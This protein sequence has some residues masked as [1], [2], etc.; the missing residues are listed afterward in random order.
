MHKQWWHYALSLV[1][2]FRIFLFEKLTAVVFVAWALMTLFAVSVASW[3]GV[4]ATL[5]V[6]VA[7]LLSYRPLQGFMLARKHLLI[8]RGDRVEYAPPGEGIEALGFEQATIL[9]PITPENVVRT[10][11]F[12][13]EHLELYSRFFLVDDGTQNRVIPYEW[14]MAIETELPEL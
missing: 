4:A 3:F 6:V 11:Q 12:D 10:E 7:A 14:I 9:R 13:A 2:V 1:L 8:R 5:T